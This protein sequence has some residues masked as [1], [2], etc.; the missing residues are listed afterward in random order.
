MKVYIAGP[1]ADYVGYNYAA[2]DHAARSLRAHGYEVYSPAEANIAEHYEPGE[3]I[4]EHH[5]E[6]LMRRNIAELGMCDEIFLLRGWESSK[7]AKIELRHAI[8][9]GL[10]IRQQGD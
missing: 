10:K 2:F 3:I 6:R 4:P 5:Y 1:M 8:E 9:L 7:G